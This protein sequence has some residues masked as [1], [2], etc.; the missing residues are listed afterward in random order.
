MVWFV[1]LDSACR[2]ELMVV[3]TCVQHIPTLDCP[4]CA[5][6]SL[7]TATRSLGPFLHLCLT[8]PFCS[9]WYGA[10]DP[11]DLI[12]PGRERWV[13][14][15]SFYGR[16]VPSRCTVQ[17]LSG[18]LLSGS[19]PGVLRRLV[20][21]VYV[22][23]FLSRAKRA[24]QDIISVQ[25]S[26]LVLT[27]NGTLQHVWG[28]PH[29]DRS[30]QIQMCE[31][32]SVV[33]IFMCCAVTLCSALDLRHNALHGTVPAFVAYLQGLT[34]VPT[35]LCEHTSASIP[36]RCAPMPPTTTVARGSPLLASPLLPCGRQLSLSWN[37]L[38]APTVT[39][40]TKPAFAALLGSFPR[41]FDGNC[42][43][44]VPLLPGASFPV[45]PGVWC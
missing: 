35:Y 1:L 3:S 9:T 24:W 19:I 37:T 17:N 33:P 45:N 39:A 16:I 14:M 8:W 43:S 27:A 42:F 34:Y 21:L 31:A 4:A 11:D 20:G 23:N 41:A 25:P 15:V 28:A 7:R 32:S 6:I 2:P 12:Y 13:H 44:Q 40:A 18:N 22:A 5:G 10:Q 30:L 38:Q 29:C 36:S 26:V